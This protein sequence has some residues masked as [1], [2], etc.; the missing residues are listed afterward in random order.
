VNNE[1]TT[2]LKSHLN[3]QDGPFILTP[4][5]PRQ[6]VALKPT[7]GPFSI[8]SNYI[9]FPAFGEGLYGVPE[10]DYGNATDPG[11]N[12][13]AGGYVKSGSHIWEY[14]QGASDDANTNRKLKII[15][16]RVAWWR[17]Y[18]GNYWHH[19]NWDHYLL[20][21]SNN[22]YK[23][24][25]PILNGVSPWLLPY[26]IPGQFDI[27]SS[28]YRNSIAGFSHWNYYSFWFYRAASLL[29]IQYTNGDVYTLKARWNK[30]P[31]VTYACPSVMSHWAGA[32]NLHSAEASNLRP[33]TQ[34]SWVNPT[35]PK[36]APDSMQG[37]TYGGRSCH[38]RR[39]MNL[40][41]GGYTSDCGYYLS[42]VWVE[43]HNSEN[44]TS[45][46][47]GLGYRHHLQGMGYP[48]YGGAYYNPRWRY[49]RSEDS[50]VQIPL[51]YAAEVSIVCNEIDSFGDDRYGYFGGYYGLYAY[52]GYYH[53]YWYY[54]RPSWRAGCGATNS[55]E[56]R[57]GIQDIFPGSAMSY[58]SQWNPYRSS[59]G[60]Q[61]TWEKVDFAINWNTGMLDIASSGDWYGVED[62][63]QVLD[64]GSSPAP[65]AAQ[66]WSGVDVGACG[67]LIW[68]AMQHYHNNYTGA[69]T[70]AGRYNND[71]QHTIATR[72]L[73]STMNCGTNNSYYFPTGIQGQPQNNWDS[74]CRSGWFYPMKEHPNGGQQ[75]E[76]G[77][78]PHSTFVST[79]D[80]F[81][82]FFESDRLYCGYWGSTYYSY[83]I[84]GRHTGE[85]IDSRWEWG[86]GGNERLWSYSKKGYTG[87]SQM[88]EEYQPWYNSS[89]NNHG[90]PESDYHY[91]IAIPG[92]SGDNH[93][94]DWW[95]N[96]SSGPRSTA[97]TP[98][99]DM[100][101][102][103][104]TSGLRDFL[105]TF[106]TET[107]TG[108]HVLQPQVPVADSCRWKEGV[109][110]CY[111]PKDGCTWYTTRG[112]VEV[113]YKFPDLIGTG[114]AKV[115]ITHEWP[116]GSYKDQGDDAHFKIAK[117]K[118]AEFSNSIVQ[119][120]DNTYDKDRCHVTQSGSIAAYLKLSG[121]PR[122]SSDYIWQGAT[123]AWTGRFCDHNLPDLRGWDQGTQFNFY[124]KKS[125]KLET[126][127]YNW[128]W[129][130]NW[131]GRWSYVPSINELITKAPAFV[132]PVDNWFNK[133][134]VDPAYGYNLEVELSYKANV[135]AN[136]DWSHETLAAGQSR[137]V[138]SHYSRN[139][140]RLD[141]PIDCNNSEDPKD[142]DDIEEI[143]KYTN[144]RTWP[145]HFCVGM[146][147]GDNYTA[148]PRGGFSASEDV[149]NFHHEIGGSSWNLGEARLTGY[150]KDLWRMQGYWKVKSPNIFNDLNSFKPCKKL[151]PPFPTPPPPAT[152]YPC[153]VGGGYGACDGFGQATWRH[154]SKNLIWKGGC[155][156]G[157]TYRVVGYRPGPPPR[158][159]ILTT[160]GKFHQGVN[161]A[162]LGSGRV[163]AFE[164]TAAGAKKGGALM[165]AKFTVYNGNSQHQLD[166]HLPGKHCVDAG[167]GNR[168]FK[169]GTEGGWGG[170]TL[171]HQYN[172]EQYLAAGCKFDAT[173]TYQFEWEYNMFFLESKWTYYPFALQ[174]DLYKPVGKLKYE[175]T[176]S[177]TAP[178]NDACTYVSWN[179]Q[180]CGNSA[181]GP[182]WWYYGASAGCNC[183]CRHKGYF[184]YWE[185]QVLQSVESPT[186]YDYIYHWY[187]YS[188]WSYCWYRYSNNPLYKGLEFKVTKGKNEY[189]WTV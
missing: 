150:Y 113:N 27:S 171:D 84:K 37:G 16:R 145:A 23:S 167:T 104:T 8:G 15:A 115:Y 53:H 25:N 71:P 127:L 160:P 100:C 42:D 31:S 58:G 90:Y 52:W 156:E 28:S 134:T 151:P 174:T 45:Q 118:I 140:P 39:M 126:S 158:W 7:N 36:D 144:M 176:W 187:C 72:P 163:K 33:G 41:N 55:R 89:S 172:G 102:P 154:T 70:Y 166:F 122:W 162:N 108:S 143:Y 103:V 181:H 106:I 161:F 155:S 177:G 114:S 130:W 65:Q 83:P 54:V 17:N 18:H 110:G 9:R 189:T 135:P 79:K 186:Y 93:Y 66:N 73:V 43:I 51:G 131:W 91:N 136:E 20:D 185:A 29:T 188:W 96:Y 78:P 132:K 101:E 95:W 157:P 180:A 128:N 50:S 30:K 147:P 62:L 60:K 105:K 11:Q 168:G 141:G 48:G 175:T 44:H 38:E 109:T 87:F 26:L 57:Q 5:N 111:H 139:V 137:N 152:W 35:W 112:Y 170:I 149:P 14:L 49:N 80:G 169:V 59:R 81:D 77:P 173:T 10:W 153:A 116:A 121:E 178:T 68:Y 119:S 86:P 165:D 125:R 142:V 32:G 82:S 107:C 85:V 133:I 63:A 22:L 76:G 4:A 24:D 94:Q 97:V 129:Q 13:W 92:P 3:L 164:M 64:D 1:G 47:T 67:G 34:D 182:H 56:S 183:D 19:W 120:A 117:K 88:Y 184:N 75:V 21:I 179:T 12:L 69:R 6:I 46:A 40:H 74:S 2:N 61:N 124:V 123:P 99:P 138:W 148:D 146:Y 98:S 159:T